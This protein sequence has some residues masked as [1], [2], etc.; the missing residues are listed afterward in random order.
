MRTGQ[1]TINFTTSTPT[2]LTTGAGIENT[3][4]LQT[5]IADNTTE[6]PPAL[7]VQV[8]ENI[9]LMVAKH[10]LS[11]V[12]S[13]MVLVFIYFVATCIKSMIMHRCKKQTVYKCQCFGCEV[14][15]KHVS[16]FRPRCIF[17]HRSRG[18]TNSETALGDIQMQ[19]LG[20]EHTRQH[21]NNLYEYVS[22][23]S[24]GTSLR[25]RSTHSHRHQNSM[26]TC[27]N[28]SWSVGRPLGRGRRAFSE[29]PNAYRL[30]DASNL[31]LTSPHEFNLREQLTY[32]NNALARQRTRE[33]DKY[34]IAYISHTS[35][36]TDSSGSREGAVGGE[37]RNLLIDN[38]SHF[39]PEPPPISSRRPLR[40][41]P[42]L[43]EEFV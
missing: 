15:A 43:T 11:G 19:A 29:P 17:G 38:I 21:D 14:T 41:H 7:V 16:S 18:R 8:K 25:R 23:T 26:A 32:T 42:S 39:N 20:E 40:E 22:R 27:T 37:S 2:N 3:T 4:A 24:S 5:S 6:I 31:S 35:T 36:S 30:Q 1:S 13:T 9:S 10:A 12:L 33:Q 34:S 28:P